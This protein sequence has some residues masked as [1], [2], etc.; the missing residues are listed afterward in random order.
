MKEYIE[1]MLHLKADILE[2]TKT[3]QLPLYLRGGYELTQLHIAGISCLL[4][5]PKEVI[6]LATLRKQ[7]IKLS[8]LTGMEC[9]FYFETVND[10][11][12]RK[13]IEEGIA[14]IIGGRQI[15]IPFLGMALTLE[16]ERLIPVVKQISFMTQRLLLTAL[17]GKWSEKTLTQAAKEMDVS[18]MSITRCFDELEALSV[19]VIYRG[20]STRQF[21]WESDTKTF[22]DTILPTLRNPV[23]KVYRIDEQIPTCPVLLGGM[24]AISN[25]S[26]LADNSYTTY[27]IP[28]AAEKQ[29]SILPLVPEGEVP[30]CVL[31]VMAYLIPYGDK[32]AVDPLS[33]ILSITDEEKSDPRVEEALDKILEEILYG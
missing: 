14:F 17:Y 24:S 13:M 27:A 21:S 7:R 10:Y 33:A 18:K 9:V 30:E 3:S 4:A 6:N 1:K 12:K 25:Y 32:R 15:Y 23:Q 26:M 2:Y 31:Q 19:P 16:K 20:N 11:S 5:K 22:Y 8:E 28:K 29:I